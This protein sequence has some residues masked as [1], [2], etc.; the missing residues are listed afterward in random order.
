MR[1]AR[2]RR[3]FRTAVP[4]AT[5]PRCPRTCGARCRPSTRA[6]ARSPR[7]H[8]RPASYARSWRFVSAHGGARASLQARAA[9]ALYSTNHVSFAGYVPPGGVAAGESRR[10]HP[11]RC[12]RPCAHQRER[13]ARSCTLER[14]E[15]RLAVPPCDMLFEPFR[16][17]QPH[18][19]YCV[20]ALTAIG[21]R[22]DPRTARGGARLP[23]AQTLG[24]PPPSLPT[25][26]PTHVPTVHSRPNSRSV[27]APHSPRAP[28]R[29]GAAPLATCVQWRGRPPPPRR[30]TP[31]ARARGLTRAR[32][33]VG[34]VSRAARRCWSGS[35]RCTRSARARRGV[36][37]R[38][39]HSLGSRTCGA[40]PPD[41]HRAAAAAPAR[42]TRRVRLVRGEGRGVST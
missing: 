39:G 42:G 10:P 35:G 14:R 25:V 1:A 2:L 3:P 8:A 38:V 18:W 12:P 33:I 34:S 29:P 11:R 27:P 21:R 40:P 5:A 24:S 32:A 26:A 22:A 20:H 13:P 30:A 7:P 36:T 9:G 15:S 17:A 28:P 6:R 31:T 37:F 19:R 41:A 16:L 4:A 23:G